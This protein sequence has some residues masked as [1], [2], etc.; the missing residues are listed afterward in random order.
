MN[1]CCFKAGNCCEK[2][3]PELCLAIE[4]Y[5]CIGPSMS[6]TRIYLQDKY[7]IRSD[8]CDNRMIR[9][10]NCLMMLACIFDILAMFE[11]SLKD[12]SQI[13]NC[14]AKVVFYSTIGC[15]GVQIDTECKYRKTEG[16]HGQN[17]VTLATPINESVDPGI[18]KIDGHHH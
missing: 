2:Q 18:K 8:P 3:C 17:P 10:T 15:M 4:S 11:P 6:S 9:F 7:D 1:C 5:C 12:C 13:L 14:I 16:A